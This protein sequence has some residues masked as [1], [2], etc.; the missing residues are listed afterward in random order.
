MSLNPNEEVLATI[1]GAR[2]RKPQGPGGV[3][4]P[5]AQRGFGRQFA[6][7]AKAENRTPV[8]ALGPDA[9]GKTTLLAAMFRTRPSLNVRWSSE[10]ALLARDRLIGAE[11]GPEFQ[12]LKD[13][14]VPNLPDHPVRATRAEL[15]F[16]LPLQLKSRRSKLPPAKLAYLESRGEFYKPVL[17][18]DADSGREFSMSK[19]FPE[20]LAEFLRCFEG[21]I[22]FIHVA[23]CDEV[24]GEKRPADAAILFGLENYQS[25]RGEAHASQDR[26]LFLL[27]KWDRIAR[28]IGLD[29][30]LTPPP[31]AVEAVLR[32]QF[33]ES[34]LKFQSMRREDAGLSH[35]YMQYIGTPNA[36]PQYADSVLNWIYR[37]IHKCDLFPAVVPPPPPG[38]MDQMRDFVG[39]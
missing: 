1:T 38:W 14:G 11:I 37:G 32:Q 13:V 6:E 17:M 25:V 23:P 8:I 18:R 16:F 19:P 31:D 35:A 33:R 30:Y 2:P 24:G 9:A 7:H 28:N 22:T 21:P 34:W 27:T 15:P 26:H 29:A 10:S 5:E 3:L 12:Y 36:H 20:V 4:E 39:L